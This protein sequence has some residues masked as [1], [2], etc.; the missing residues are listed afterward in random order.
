MIL[1]VAE[2][3]CC[4]RT[5]AIHARELAAVTAFCLLAAPQR[6]S[7]TWIVGDPAVRYLCASVR[8]S[9]MEGTTMA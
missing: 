1:A 5:M 4:G 8:N 2:H 7:A 6:R 9:F 3:P